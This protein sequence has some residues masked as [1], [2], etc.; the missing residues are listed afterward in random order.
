[1]LGRVVHGVRASV[2]LKP[3]IPFNSTLPECEKCNFEP[4][5]N[6]REGVSQPVLTSEIEAGCGESV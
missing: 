1:M 6:E 5:S 2:S 3:E 4:V